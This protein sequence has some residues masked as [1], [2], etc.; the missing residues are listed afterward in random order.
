[1]KTQTPAAQNKRNTI[2]LT[3]VLVVF[4]VVF[5]A[6]IPSVPFH[7]DESTY[8]FMSSDLEILFTDP[9]TI[10]W[11]TTQQG[12]LRQNYRT[13][14]P[15]L[16]RNMVAIGRL[17]AGQPAL[18]VDWDWSQS[19]QQNQ[20]AGALPDDSLLFTCRLSVAIF[21]PLTL[22]FLYLSAQKI[23]GRTAA[24]IAML[25]MA[26]SAL[27]LLH[28]RRAMSESV[29]VFFITLSLYFLL[30]FEEKPWLSSIP[31][32]LA[33]NSKLSA[34]PLLAVGGLLILIVGFIRK[35]PVKKILVQAVLYGLVILLI[36][37]ALNPYL[38]AHPL[39]AA[40]AA[41][42][43]RLELTDRQ[44]G[45]VVTVSPEQVLDSTPKRIGNL[46]AHLF[47]TPPAIADVANYLAETQNAS[48]VYLSNPLHS[49]GRSIVIGAILLVLCLTGII[50]SLVDAVRRKSIALF[51]LALAGFSQIAAILVLVPLPFQ[52]YILPALPFA[53]IWTAYGP[54]RF[55]QG[56][57][58]ALNKKPDLEK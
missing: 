25:L 23:A 53:C 33:V 51:T 37:F 58:T 34:A 40:R 4:T 3:L 29:L 26:G 17:V 48:D 47:F 20:Q 45:T 18:Q 22:L 8:I 57:Q 41:W 35:W 43:A 42:Q 56:I 32:A 31:I 12:S 24:W 52:R 7:P 36:S 55:I 10:F 19:W 39:P 28:T 30:R 54:T 6:G 44:V 1:M 2:S 27:S 21:Y 50:F 5:L 16:P 46:I 9:Q 15:P 49:L 11:Q 14:D 13:L 38:W